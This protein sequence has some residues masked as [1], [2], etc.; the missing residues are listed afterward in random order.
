MTTNRGYTF[1]VSV[2]TR[3]HK[4][5]FVQHTVYKLVGVE[6]SGWA[7]ICQDESTCHYVDP[8]CLREMRHPVS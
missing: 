1:G 5:A 7:L 6:Q 4:G 3:N 8:D 2:G